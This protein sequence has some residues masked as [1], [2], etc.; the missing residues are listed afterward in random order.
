MIVACPNCGKKYQVD[1]NKIT[2]ANPKFICQSCQH[3][4]AVKNPNLDSSE[5][6][7]S[8]ASGAKKS[9]TTMKRLGLR[10]K[11]V[12]FFVVIPVFLIGAFG[13]S[14]VDQ[15]MDL[16]TIITGKS[17]T[18]VAGMA[19]DIISEHARSVAA[20]TKLYL[21]YNPGMVKADFMNSPEL[22]RIAIQKVGNTGYSCLYS[23]PDNE[24]KSSLWIHPNAKLI[25]IDLPKAMKKS[26]GDEYHRWW[27]V[28]NG[29]YKGQESKGYYTWRDADNRLREKFMVCTP[30]KGTDY[31]I[32]STTYIDEFTEPM[33]S[34]E[35]WAQQQTQSIRTNVIIA[36]L[37]SFVLISGIVT[38][39]GYRL[40]KKIRRVTEVADRISTG[41]LD[42]ELDIQSNDEIG[43]LSEAITRM[44]DSI[45]MSIQRLKKRK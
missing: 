16:S 13:V 7:S 15:L 2:G 35:G 19:E 22:K 43:D 3:A 20:N 38:F 40:T 27:D 5:S 8:S 41:E 33:K 9:S 23:V 37:A 31:I 11:M 6:L 25:G 18:M 17:G 34:L 24:G 14:F 1:P 10:G 29:A 32:A 44:K 12:L 36:L 21:D 42:A 39:Y 26:L 45:R 28:Y 30:I 4:V